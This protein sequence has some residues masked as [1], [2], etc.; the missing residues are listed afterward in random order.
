L[1]GTSDGGLGVIV[2]LPDQVFKWVN[3]KVLCF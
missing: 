1:F 2:Q 3:P